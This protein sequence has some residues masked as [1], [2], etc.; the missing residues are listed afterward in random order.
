M[1]P[2]PLDDAEEADEPGLPREFGP[3]ELLEELGRG[4]MGVVYKA[5]Q[6]DL[7]RIVAEDDSG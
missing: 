1:A 4:G 5:R 3:Y 7:D 6:K 2:G